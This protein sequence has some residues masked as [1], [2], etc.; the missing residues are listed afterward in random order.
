MSAK[1]TSHWAASK[2]GDCLHA[3]AAGWILN[4]D[5]CS[6]C[7]QRFVTALDAIGGPLEWHEDFRRRAEPHGETVVKP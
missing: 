3:M 6:H 1:C 4:N 7:T 5:L 2:H